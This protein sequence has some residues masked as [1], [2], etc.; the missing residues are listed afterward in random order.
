[1]ILLYI[2]KLYLECI[3]I[4]LYQI[5]YLNEMHQLFFIIIKLYFNEIKV[6]IFYLTF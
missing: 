3:H 2:F 4:F 6:W 1:M 5:I